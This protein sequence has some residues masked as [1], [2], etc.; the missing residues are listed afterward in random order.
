MC[1]KLCVRVRVH[2][3]TACRQTLE[4][5]VCEREAVVVCEADLAC[6]ASE[7]SQ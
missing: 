1:L 4:C 3:W 5:D 2:A 7:V 6:E